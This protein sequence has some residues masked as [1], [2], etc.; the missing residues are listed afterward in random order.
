MKQSIDQS[1][2][3]FH[4]GHTEIY[5]LFRQYALYLINDKGKKKIGAKMIVERIRWNVFVNVTD[6]D[7]K[8]NNSHTSRYARMFIDEYPQYASYFEL[9]TIHSDPVQQKMF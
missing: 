2:H 9:R 6:A 1:F 3:E 4:R 7:Y 5:N 8:I